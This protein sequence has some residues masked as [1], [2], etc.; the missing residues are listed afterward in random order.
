MLVLQY[1]FNESGSDR[2]VFLALGRTC[3]VLLWQVP[4]PM[5]AGLVSCTKLSQ[6]LIGT[7][8][9]KSST[10]FFLPFL[11]GFLVFLVLGKILHL[12][13]LL[14]VLVLPHKT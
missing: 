6:S 11:I 5:I 10:H 12:V 14:L 8:K 1:S 9:D 3:P 13:V 2:I 4:G 7:H